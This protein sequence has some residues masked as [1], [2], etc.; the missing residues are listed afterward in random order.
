MGL[1]FVF[2]VVILRCLFLISVVVPTQGTAPIKMD[3]KGP[4]DRTEQFSRIPS[5]EL[6]TLISFF[7]NLFTSSGVCKICGCLNNEALKN[8]TK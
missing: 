6:S 4:A 8:C 1:N 2:S 3:E 7:D 5:T